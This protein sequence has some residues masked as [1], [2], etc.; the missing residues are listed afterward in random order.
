MVD[1]RKDEKTRVLVKATVTETLQQL[2]LYTDKE[3]IEEFRAN[4]VFVQ[5]AR[6][7][8]TRLRAMVWLA[9]IGAVFT[10]AGGHIKD[11]WAA[12]QRWIG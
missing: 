8:Y 3:S 5:E 4:M 2:G 12:F 11:A 10:F 6:V 1:Q 9:V 7:G